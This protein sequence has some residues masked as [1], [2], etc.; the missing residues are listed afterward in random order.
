MVGAIAETLA[1]HL[2]DHID[3]SGV[4]LWLA[5]RQCAQ[6][7]ELGGDEQHRL[8]QEIVLGIG[9]VRA[10]RA[11]DLHPQVFHMNEG[12]AWFLTLE[13][14]R[15]LMEDGKMSF[16]EAF[17]YVWSTSIFTTHT[18]VEAGFDRF[19]PAL[20]GQYLGTYADRLGIGLGGFLA[21]GRRE[22]GNAAEP[23]NMAYLAFRAS[24]IVNGVSRLHGEVS[25][26]IFRDLFP[27]W[28]LSEVPVTH[29]TNGVH[30]PSWDS[31][32]TDALWH[33]ACGKKRWV[34]TMST[35]EADLKLV[36][37]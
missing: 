33:E 26:R 17:Q 20:V 35:I 34:G 14:I 7:A 37:D 32:A 21:L 30:V 29:V 1:V 16:K 18:P 5:L 11:L 10:L 8:R 15:T 31:A 3:H 19:S 6:M 25:R 27:R 13:R 12:H 23:L 28:P 24:N 9:G 22:P 4:A 2:V 36:A